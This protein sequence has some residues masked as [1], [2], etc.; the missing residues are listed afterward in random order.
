MQDLTQS[1]RHYV[2]RNF[3]VKLPCARFLGSMAGREMLSKNRISEM[4]SLDLVRFNLLWGCS[5]QLVKMS[6][7]VLCASVL[8]S[9]KPEK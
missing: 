1:S 4:R 9:V 6:H 5:S 7:M 2:N 3:R 8:S